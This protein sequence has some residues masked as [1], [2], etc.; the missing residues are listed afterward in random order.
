LRGQ[1]APQNQTSE[2]KKLT[3]LSTHIA[4]IRWH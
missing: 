3:V 1:M 4:H 2:T